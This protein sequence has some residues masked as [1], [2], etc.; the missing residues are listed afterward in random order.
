MLPKIAIL[1][2]LARSGGTLVS[3]CLGCMSGHI[4]LSEINPRA[5]HFNPLIQANEWFKLISDDELNEFKRTR[6]TSYVES[7]RVIAQRCAEK[8]Y[9]LIIR[10][11]SH[12]DFF[13]GRYYPVPPIYRLS[14]Y[15][16]LKKDFD[17]RR[18]ALVRHPLDTLLS[19]QRLS[20]YR[21][22]IDVSL[23]IKGFRHFAQIASE[24]GF[25]RYEEFCDQ[26]QAVIERMCGILEVSYDPGFLEKYQQYTKITGDII[27]PGQQHTVTGDR[28][29]ERSSN[30]AI[31]RPPRR[32]APPELLQKLQDDG[33][34]QESLRILNYATTPA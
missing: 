29:G 19:I 1:H 33:N 23:S 6:C 34:Y 22:G 14:Q 32:T 5:A 17:I 10:D 28:I 2:S 13:P 16:V 3:K 20:N 15:E 7:I 11:W 21:D 25:I 4:L 12:I 9:Q 31:R 18:I 24:I 26:P 8:G 30:D 27:H